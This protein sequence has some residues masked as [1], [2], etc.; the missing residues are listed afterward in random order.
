M[1]KSI[2][3]L[4]EKSRGI[5]KTSPLAGEVGASLQVRGNNKPAGGTKSTPPAPVILG[6]VPRILLQRVPNLVNKFALLLH[7][8]WL[9][10]DSW[11]KPKNDWCWGRWFSLVASKQRSVAHG[12]KVMDT[13]LPQPAGCGDKYDV[14]GWG[15]RLLR[16]ARNDEASNGE[17][18]HRPWCHQSS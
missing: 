14:S 6:L 18:L 8:F 13:R 11:N 16:C 7:K 1:L 17:G 5:Y 9:R 10:E 15:Y 4:S 12:N 2:K 3:F